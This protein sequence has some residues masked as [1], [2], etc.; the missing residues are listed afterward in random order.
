[1]MNR[2]PLLHIRRLLAAGGDRVG[3]YGFDRL[4]QLVDLLAEADA[5]TPSAGFLAAGLLPVDQDRPPVLFATEETR[6]GWLARWSERL[7]ASTYSSLLFVSTD[8]LDEPA[9][10]SAGDMPLVV[11]AGVVPVSRGRTGRPLVGMELAEL[12]GELE[13]SR[14][15]LSEA[16]GFPIR[17]LAPAPTATGR[18]IDGLV[19]REARR[20][21]YTTLLKPGA[22]RPLATP[23]PDEPV[24]YYTCQPDDDPERLR[25]WVL[26][27]LVARGSTRLKQLTA[28]PR[29]WLERFS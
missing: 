3:D 25:D 20:A 1:M 27:G 8:A 7:A 19:A 18:A 4:D 2:L 5:E 14:E 26:G 10:I 12:R 15:R 22:G 23:L 24:P 29:A 28:T 11:G 21:G 16:A 9:E 13:E 6:T 17:M